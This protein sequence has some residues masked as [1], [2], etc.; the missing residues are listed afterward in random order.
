MK[1]VRLSIIGFGAVGQGVAR[2]IISKHDYLHKLGI[3]LRVVGISDSGGCEVDT[4]GVDLK[5]AIARKK[6]TGTVA[7]DS[8]KDPVLISDIDHDI[9]VEATPTNIK[10]GE[11]GLGNM[12][13]AFQSGKHVVTSN[14]GPLALHFA[15]L[16]EAA[17]D[18]G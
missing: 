2:S 9:V 7:V 6:Q 10:D 18:N 1:T 3:H 5:E 13:S 16:K 14:K 17:E 11:P 4:E 8:G 12:L 15:E